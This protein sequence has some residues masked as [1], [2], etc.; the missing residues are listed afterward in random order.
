MEKL[1]VAKLNELARVE[2]LKEIK[3]NG[4]TNFL[5]VEGTKYAKDFEFDAGG[6]LVTKTVR[7]DIV[8]PKLDEE[9]NAETLAE[10][11]EFRVAEKEKNA[12]AKAE[13]KAKKIARDEKAR[14]KKKAEKEAE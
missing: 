6:E 12:K 10:D 2:A 11:Y 13:A 1:T 7:I 8:V 9:E 5:Q 14:A 3:E 4:L